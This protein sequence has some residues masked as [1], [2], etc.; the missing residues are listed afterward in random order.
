M[1][2]EVA[3]GHVSVETRKKL[4]A[5]LTSERDPDV[6]GQYVH[7]QAWQVRWAAIESLGKS[8]SRDA[9][10][11]LLAVLKTN[12]DVRDYPW[13]N[14]ALGRVGSKAAIP[15]L[16]DLIHHPVEDVKGTAIA[17]L[18]VVGDASLTP[19][20]LDALSD[21]NWVAKWAAMGA[22][23]RNAD[24][25]AVAPVSARVRSILTRQRTRNLGGTTEVMYA[26][27][28]LDRWS[29]SSPIAAETIRWVRAKALA[30]LLSDERAW[31]E[32]KFGA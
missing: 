2:T 15:A 29:T 5:R 28:F 23:A 14:V 24:E 13:A 31:F 20:Y 8:G 17:A 22:I 9:E 4:V 21:R 16:I 3:R 30:R 7:H 19:T 18:G 27:E 25:R 32:T 26:L 11:P 10:G 1:L 12:P 6:L